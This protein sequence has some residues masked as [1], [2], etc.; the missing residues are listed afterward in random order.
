MFCN[1]PNRSTF[2]VTQNNPLETSGI[3]LKLILENVYDKLKLQAIK[4]VVSFLCPWMAAAR[5]EVKISNNNNRQRNSSDNA[6]TTSSITPFSDLVS[7]IGN[8]A[9]HNGAVYLFRSSFKTQVIL[10]ARLRKVLLA[11]R[12]EAVKVPTAIFLCQHELSQTT[13]L[14]LSIT[15]NQ[16]FYSIKMSSRYEK[17]SCLVMIWIRSEKLTTCDVIKFKTLSIFKHWNHSNHG[18]SMIF[19]QFPSFCANSHVY[20]LEQ[21]INWC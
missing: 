10:T 1:L 3:K 16:Y 8:K 13:S 2:W 21:Q 14:H 19:R 6:E 17:W 4:I 20:L 7:N 9:N 11:V 15:K 5:W 12:A 18:K